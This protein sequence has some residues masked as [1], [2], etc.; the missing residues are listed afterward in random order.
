MSLEQLPHINAALNFLAATL[1]LIGYGLI[2]MDYERAHKWTM[3]AAFATSVGFLIC[4][5][6]YHQAVGLGRHFTGTGFIRTVY[7]VILVSHVLLAGLIPLLA[8]L[9]IYF[10]LANERLYHRRMAKVALPIW[11]YVSVTGVL[12]YLFLYVL[13]PAGPVQA[14]I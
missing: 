14:T 1:L 7:L 13:Y 10:G 4:Y 9:T 12:I 8:M 11:L 5:L 3:L 2:K 6:I